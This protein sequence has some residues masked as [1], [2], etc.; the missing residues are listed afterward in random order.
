MPVFSCRHVHI[1]SLLDVRRDRHHQVCE[2]LER[3]TRDA[4]DQS[5]FRRSVETHWRSISSIRTRFCWSAGAALISACISDVGNIR[6]RLPPDVRQH[7][8]SR[9]WRH[10]LTQCCGRGAGAAVAV[11]RWDRKHWILRPYPMPIARSLSRFLPRGSTGG[12]LPRLQVLAG[13]RIFNTYLI[14]PVGTPAAAASDLSQALESLRRDV[15]QTRIRESG[16]V[17]RC[18]QFR[19]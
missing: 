9:G 14:D 17:I 3:C 4:F 16:R 11:A 6:L 18:G 12:F 1:E 15:R 8:S 19:K 7:H 10:C 2:R 5:Q 13:V